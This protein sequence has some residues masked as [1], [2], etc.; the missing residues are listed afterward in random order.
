MRGPRGAGSTPACR[1]VAF[2]QQRDLEA[3]DPLGIPQAP[4]SSRSV[5]TSCDVWPPARPGQPPGVSGVCCISQPEAVGEAESQ[6]GGTRGPNSGKHPTLLGWPPD[7]LQEWV[8]EVAMEKAE[9]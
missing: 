2:G 8:V 4:W 7:G 1:E 9:H 6:R 5:H 3:E